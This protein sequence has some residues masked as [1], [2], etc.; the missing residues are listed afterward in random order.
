METSSNSSSPVLGLKPRQSH[1]IVYIS[2]VVLIYIVVLASMVN[3]ALGSTLQL[4]MILLTSCLG[5]ILPSPSL[6]IPKKLL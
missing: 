3:I 2:Q 1:I 5:Y 6:K 4:W